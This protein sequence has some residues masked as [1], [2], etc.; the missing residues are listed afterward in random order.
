M[1]IAVTI[2]GGRHLYEGI[3]AVGIGHKVRDL[4][5][6]YPAVGGAKERVVEVKDWTRIEIDR[7]QEQANG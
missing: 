6:V 2:G 3:S 1:S 5:L 4:V 7:T